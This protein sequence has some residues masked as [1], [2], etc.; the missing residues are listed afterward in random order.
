MFDDPRPGAFGQQT[1]S[2]ML[3]FNA[4]HGYLDAILRG[5]K[6]GLI[7]RSQYTNFTQ[8]ESIE[9]LRI[10]LT[11]STDYGEVLADL[12][13][14]ALK[15][16]ILSAKLREKYVQDFQYLRCNASGKLAEFLD[17]VAIEYMIGNVVMIVR[18]V[19]RGEEMD[20]EE[21]MAQCHPLGL[22]D[23][24]PALTVSKNLEELYNTVLIETPLGPYFRE[25]IVSDP[26]AELTEL[27]VEIIRLSLW[28][29]YLEDFAAWCRTNTDPVTAETMDELLGFEADRRTISILVN[30]VGR[31]MPRGLVGRVVPRMG[32]IWASGCLERLALAEDPG[33]IRTLIET[34]VPAYRSLI[35]A[36]LS[37]TTSPNLAPASTTP[38]I[39]TIIPS[40]SFEFLASELE[41]SACK[42]TFQR[43]FS[44]APFYAWTRLR[45]QEGRNLVW[46]AECIAQH[47]KENVHH[48]IPL[49]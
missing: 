35:S 21:L 46:I 23:L 30:S 9:D 15:P 2:Q 25:L 34:F 48:Y 32:K 41:M 5:F 18:G 27:N 28:K 8:C 26:D 37:S 43:Q 17:F 47:Q 13:G 22:V 12:N 11:T 6:S 44:L 3:W 20:R 16:S 39:D 38:L 49:F 1:C 42:D 36:A 33:Q 19:M 29:S 45:E 24:M 10:Q 4:D 14:V 31:G 40:A 7:T